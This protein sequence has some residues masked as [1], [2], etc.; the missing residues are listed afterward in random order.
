LDPVFILKKVDEQFYIFH[1]HINIAAE[2][3]H[4]LRKKKKKEIDRPDPEL[5]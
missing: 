4:L 5:K 3:F 2:I 1:H